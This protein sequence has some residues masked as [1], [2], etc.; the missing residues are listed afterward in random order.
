MPRG[1][2]TLLNLIDRGEISGKIAKSLLDEL[3]DTG[4]DPAELVRRKGMAQ[5][6]DSAEIAALVDRAM[7]ENPKVVADLLAGKDKAATYLVGQVMKYSRGRANPGL[8]NSLI[9]KRISSLRS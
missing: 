2:A 5:I 7:Q 9:A 3:C 1:L 6:S 8:V 4:A